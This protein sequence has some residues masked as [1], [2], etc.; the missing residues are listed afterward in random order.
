MLNACDV[1]YYFT[2]WIKWTAIKNSNISTNAWCSTAIKQPW[3]CDKWK[4][5]Y[6]HATAA[7]SHAQSS[8]TINWTQRFY[9]LLRYNG[10]KRFHTASRD[11]NICQSWRSGYIHSLAQSRATIRRMI[12]VFLTSDKNAFSRKW[13]ASRRSQISSKYACQWRHRRRCT[14][15][16]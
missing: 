3:Q 13:P 5:R 2:R 7:Y 11:S 1:S 6:M 4:Q 9:F 12:K 10:K 14:L 8:Q 16:I 15:L